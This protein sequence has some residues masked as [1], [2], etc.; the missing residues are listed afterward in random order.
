MWNDRVQSPRTKPHVRL[1]KSLPF[2]AILYIRPTK[3]ALLSLV[4]QL[5]VRLQRSCYLLPLR[6]LQEGT[7]EDA[8]LHPNCVVLLVEVES[9]EESEGNA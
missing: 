5:A 7:L 3:D 4:V 9:D 6:V 2:P 8:G 1:R